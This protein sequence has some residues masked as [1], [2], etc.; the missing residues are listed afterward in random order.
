MGVDRP[1]GAAAGVGTF[2]VELAAARA[3][4]DGGREVTEPITIIVERTN[5]G[6]RARCQNITT[7]GHKTPREAVAKLSIMMW[8]MPDRW[9]TNELE[10]T[11][12]AR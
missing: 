8:D 7:S 9:W 6:W 1:A 4:A 3:Q 5:K 2:V 10:P 11:A 12:A